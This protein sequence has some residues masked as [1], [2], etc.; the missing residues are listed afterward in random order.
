MTGPF[1]LSISVYWTTVYKTIRP[2]LSGRC[3]V[4]YVLFVCLSVSDVGVLWPNGWMDQN[5]TW[6][7]GRPRPRRHCVSSPPQKS[8]QFSAHVCCG[9]TARWIKMPLGIE[10]GDIALDGDPAIPQKGHSPRIFGPCYCGQK[11]G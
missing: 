5:E 1:L 9:Q 3:P 6:N 4:L 8:P 11:A 2:M 7:G 10:V